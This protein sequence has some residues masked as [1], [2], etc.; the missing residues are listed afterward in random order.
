MESKPASPVQKKPSDSQ[1]KKEAPLIQVVLLP[2]LAILTGLLIGAFVILA[3]GGNVVV[4][5]GALFAG[6]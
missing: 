4:A 5:Y 2:F 1:D 6:S 3:A